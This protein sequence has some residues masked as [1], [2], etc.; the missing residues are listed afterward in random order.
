MTK[1]KL[2]SFIDRLNKNKTDGL[3]HLRP[4]SATV[5]FA[6][7]WTKKPKPIDDISFPDGPKK[8]YFIKNLD[9]IF[10]ATVYDMDWGLQWFVDTK[11]RRNG[12][13]VKAM[14]ETILFHL[15]QD[16][17]EQRITINK[18][19]IGEKNFIAS[20]KV[21]LELGFVK[22]DNNDYML[23]KS[24][25]HTDKSIFGQNT[26]LTEGRIKE[27]KRQVNYL[28]RSLWVIQS[29]IEMKLGDTDYAKELKKLVDEIKIHTLQLEDA[30]F[31][32]IN[33]TV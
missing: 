31:E 30:W 28:G 3:L 29:E 4:L 15:F 33:A 13:I 22:T 10:V 26:Q 21:A 19:E 11:H 32:S 20:Q 8:F 6:K 5:D 24:K 12:H 1:E 9:G 17:E 16:R 25:Y 7:I 2:K 27:L 23:S 18:N 14:K